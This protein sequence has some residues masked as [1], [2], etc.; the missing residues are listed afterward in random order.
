MGA[1]GSSPAGPP[2]LPVLERVVSGPPASTS[3]R[4]NG[5]GFTPLGR[6]CGERAEALKCPAEGSEGSEGDHP[7]AGCRRG[8]GGQEGAPE[9]PRTP[10]GSSG[11]P[12]L[13]GGRRPRP[14]FPG[15]SA[16]GWRP[17]LTARGPGLA[18]PAAGPQ[19]SAGLRGWPGPGHQLQDAGGATGAGGRSVAASLGS[20]REPQGC[21]M[22]VGECGGSASP[23][24]CRAGAPWVPP[25]PAGQ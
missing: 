23:S 1:L 5:R 12:G 19:L 17:A 4:P 13:P 2:Q 21:S 14:R 22:A 20:R 6:W 18:I 25:G 8:Q 9:P 16:E 3:S 10:Q 15:R 7:A 24:A 11:L